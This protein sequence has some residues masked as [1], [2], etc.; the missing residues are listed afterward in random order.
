MHIV[1]LTRKYAPATG[2]METFSMKLNEYCEEPHTTIARGQKKQWHIIWAAPILLFHAYRLRK[3]ATQYHLGDLVL[4]PLAPCIRLFSN[5][6]IVAT[7]H[8]LELTYNSTLLR[9]LIRWGKKHITHTV[10]VSEYSKQLAI[11]AGLTAETVSVITHGVDTPPAYDN[12]KG[13]IYIQSI[14]PKYPERPILLTVG[15][16]QKR[17]GVEWFIR[18][19]LPSLQ[20]MN[21]L[22][23]ITSL[24][25]ELDAI[26]QAI[27]ETD[28]QKFVRLLGKVTD[29]ELEALYRQSTAFIMPNISVPHDAE[30]FGFVSIE[31]AIRGLPVF[32]S[33]I[34]GI[35]S[36]IHHNKN[37]ILI[38]SANSEQ[39]CAVLQDYLQNSKKLQTLAENGKTYTAEHFTWK[40]SALKYKE[41]FASLTS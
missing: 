41:L 38:K 20:D 31:A 39:W 19:V 37:G 15:R 18:N 5:A 8:A 34:E 4:A 7:V 36:A 13:K 26:Q 12:K 30:G 33:D 9:A 27:E 17:K 11:D 23:L 2:G 16:L 40:H 24:G 29:E 28:Q 21:P 6:P 35:P 3:V 1:F 32:A 25:P 10:A 14:D 22:Y